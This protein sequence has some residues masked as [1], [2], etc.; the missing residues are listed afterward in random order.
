MM[1][2]S[3]IGADEFMLDLDDMD[4]FVNK[5]VML[6]EEEYVWQEPYQGLPDSPGIDDV[7]DQENS[8]KDVDTYAFFCAEV[9][10]PYE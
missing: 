5:E 2:E 9:C 3:A 4:T 8:E 1:L 6:Q 7:V 10:L